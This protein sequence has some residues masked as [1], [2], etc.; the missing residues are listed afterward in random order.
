MLACS[1]PPQIYCTSTCLG[2]LKPM[3]WSL[4]PLDVES[5]RSRPARSRP[6]RVLRLRRRRRPGFG[7]IQPKFGRDSSRWNMGGVLLASLRCRWID[8]TSRIDLTCRIDSTSRI[9]LTSRIYKNQSDQF[10]DS[11]RFDHSNGFEHSDLIVSST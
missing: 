11:D 2:S 9:D 8:S 6:E 10:D 1:E 7:W 3:D 5:L 4:S